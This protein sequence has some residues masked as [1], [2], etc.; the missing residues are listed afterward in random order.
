MLKVRAARARTETD[1]G[2]TI[3]P[4][5]L[6]AKRASVRQYASWP[7]AVRSASSTMGA[8]VVAMESKNE[9]ESVR[10]AP[11]DSARPGSTLQGTE[12]GWRGTGKGA[13][14]K[15]DTI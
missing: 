6:Y 1:T 13:D 2:E 7:V 15:V 14:T 10:G 12:G 3:D 5:H 11:R 4:A 9:R 8:V